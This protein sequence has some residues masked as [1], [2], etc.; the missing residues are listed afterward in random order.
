[1]KLT[2]CWTSAAAVFGLLALAQAL[3]HFSNN[4][5]NWVEFT[6]VDSTEASSNPKVHR[7]TFHLAVHH[8]EDVE[9]SE[10]KVVAARELDLDMDITIQDEKLCMNMMKVDMGV[11][12]VEVN[13]RVAVD[14]ADKDVQSGAPIV[15]HRVLMEIL[16][17]KSTFR[18]AQGQTIKRISLVE[19]ILEFGESKI[20]ESD[21]MEL[22]LDV[23]PNGKI[24]FHQ[25]NVIAAVPE[26]HRYSPEET[27]RIH[28]NRVSPWGL[29][30][31]SSSSLH[32]MMLRLAFWWNRLPQASR[33]IF[34]ASALSVS[35]LTVVVFPAWLAICYYRKRIV[36]NRVS[37]GCENFDYLIESTLGSE[38]EK[39]DK[40]GFAVQTTKDACV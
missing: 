7:Q 22:I 27:A 4:A 6:P 23:M 13:A 3:P 36:E 37:N 32:R 35:A 34:S 31:N 1:M 33:L 21:F 12:N 2:F 11:S 19:R 20:S 14:D 40:R 25:A 29:L 17:R 26:T 8:L 5:F 24:I 10:H 15:F 16:A 28:G 30:Q 38:K 39:D 9:N 18:N